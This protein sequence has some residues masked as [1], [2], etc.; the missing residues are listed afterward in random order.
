[1][2]KVLCIAAAVAALGVVAMPAS[3]QVFI[4]AD[5]GGAGVQ[6]GPLGVGVGPRFSDDRYYDRRG[7][8]ANAYYTGECRIVR[9]RVVRNGHVSYRTR[10]ICN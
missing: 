1:M 10:R 6:L 7:Y 2:R 5:R 3:A 9:A 8:D 4:G